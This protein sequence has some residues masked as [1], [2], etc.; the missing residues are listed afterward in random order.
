[1]RNRSIIQSQRGIGYVI[2]YLIFKHKIICYLIFVVILVTVNKGVLTLLLIANNGF[3]LV[4][5][6]FSFYDF[7]TCGFYH[8]FTN[9]FFLSVSN[10]QGTYQFSRN[11]SKVSKHKYIKTFIRE[12]DQNKKVFL[13][14]YGTEWIFS[15]SYCGIKRKYP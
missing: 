4:K 12:Q 7:L 10:N 6:Q 8:T 1:M 13:A 14:P 11:H 5:R 2:A 9:L 3:H 15:G